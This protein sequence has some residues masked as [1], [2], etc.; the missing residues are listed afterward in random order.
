[1]K[2]KI[3]KIVLASLLAISLLTIVGGSA[4]IWILFP[5]ADLEYQNRELLRTVGTLEQDIKDLEWKHE[6]EEIRRDQEAI[7]SLTEELATAQKKII[8]LEDQREKLTKQLGKEIRGSWAGARDFESIEEL[9]Q[10]LIEDDTDKLQY[11]VEDWDCDDSQLNL[12]RNSRMV[13]NAAKR[14]FRI[15]PAEAFFISGNYLY[16]WHAM[17]YAIVT[18]S[19][20]DG[21]SARMVVIIEPQTDEVI[22]LGAEDMP[23]TWNRKIFE[24]LP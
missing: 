19:F 15:Y 10:F 22:V 18:K 8:Y 9:M 17:V 20:P 23:D 2:S 14:G 3:T 1:M 16:G 13:N 12:M 5:I 7:T 6:L 21:K 4:G 11:L 24:F